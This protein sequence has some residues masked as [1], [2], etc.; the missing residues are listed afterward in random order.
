[1]IGPSV[2]VCIAEAEHPPSILIASERSAPV[3]GYIEVARGR[4]GYIDGVVG[5]LPGGIEGKLKPFGYFYPGKYL[6]FLFGRELN[7]GGF[8]ITRFG[9]GV[10]KS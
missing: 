9:I 1:L 3:T 8:D 10:G 4:G 7:D 2:V 5:G 6:G